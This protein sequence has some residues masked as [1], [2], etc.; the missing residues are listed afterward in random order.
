MTLSGKKYAVDVDKLGIDWNRQARD[1]DERIA[2]RA[3]VTPLITWRRAAMA[4]AAL[5]VVG[6]LGIYTYHAHDV[7]N[8]RVTYTYANVIESYDT[9]TSFQA[10][11]GY[12][13]MEEYDTAS[14]TSY[15]YSTIYY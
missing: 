1:I 2:A 3:R 7:K 6:F 9:P 14:D 5:L 11:N 4:A 12:A 15:D 10:L 13:E 8:G